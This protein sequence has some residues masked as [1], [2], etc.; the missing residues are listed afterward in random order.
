M[1]AAEVDDILFFREPSI[2][3]PLFTDWM[4]LIDD[5]ARDL[6]LIFIVFIWRRTKKGKKRLSTWKIE[7]L[8]ALK[9]KKKSKICIERTQNEIDAFV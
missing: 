4:R 3:F 6:F 8:F 5:Y 9:D 1:V 7:I 2:L